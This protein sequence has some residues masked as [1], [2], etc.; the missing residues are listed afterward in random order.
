MSSKAIRFYLCA[1]LAGVSIVPTVHAAVPTYVSDALT[2]AVT[3]LTDY[4]GAAA[5]HVL[6]S[7]AIIG[8]LTL[9]VR[10]LKRAFVGD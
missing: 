4:M 10:L 9:I 6:A 3:T 8:G 2:A 1:I 5:P 7:V